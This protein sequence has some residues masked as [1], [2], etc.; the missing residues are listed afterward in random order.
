MTVYPQNVL[1]RN[2]NT[3]CI[4]KFKNVIKIKKKQQLYATLAFT[5][6]YF[7]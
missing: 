6:I 4:I 5:D 3:Y 7:D 1:Q 2:Q